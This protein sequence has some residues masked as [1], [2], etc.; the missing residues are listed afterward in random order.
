MGLCPREFS[1]IELKELNERG[2]EIGV[3][4]DRAV[5]A[6]T[7]DPD[8]ESDWSLNKKEGVGKNQNKTK[9]NKQKE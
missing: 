8:F 1:K 7:G 4:E 6:K 9:A 3:V 5:T 2:K